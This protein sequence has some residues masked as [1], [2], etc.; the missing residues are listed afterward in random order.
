MTT[1]SGF[2]PPRG[3][4]TP[5]NIPDPKPK[6]LAGW[7]A[8]LPLANS[9]YC[10]DAVEAVL[11]S[12]NNNANLAAP[13]RLELAELLRPAVCMLVQR[14]ENHFIDAPLPHHP[15]AEFYAGLALR[16][17]RGLE[18]AYALAAFDPECAQG[19]FNKGERRLLQALYRAL[20]QGGLILLRTAQQYQTPPVDLWS[21]LY[22][23]YRIAEARNLLSAPFKDGEEPEA[24]RTPLGM[25]NRCLLF[26]LTSTRHLRQ[27]DMLHV[28]DLFGALADRAVL[29]S[30]A[31]QDWQTAE[32]SIHLDEDRPPFRSDS[33]GHPD[34]ANLRFL[35]TWKLTRM[36]ANAADAPEEFSV[37]DKPPINKAVLSRVV[38]SLEGIQ[39]RK[40]ERKPKDGTCRCLVGL[41]KI[42]GALSLPSSPEESSSP[43]SAS[44]FTVA[45]RLITRKFD[46]FSE[47]GTPIR[48]TGPGFELELEPESE[49]YNLYPPPP[50]NEIGSPKI[51]EGKFSARENIREAEETASFN[52][53]G[54]AVEGRIANVGARD[55]CIVWPADQVAEIKVGELIGVDEDGQSSLFIGVIRWLHCG[56]GRVRF[57]VELL[58]LSAEVA[59]LLDNSHHPM[60]KG[61]LLPSEP[62]LRSSPEL[63]TLPG[64]IQPGGMVCLG[65]AAQGKFYRV[66][67][68]LKGT[69]SF[70][71]FAIAPA[72]APVP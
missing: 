7:L 43:P 63:L 52:E 62:D 11:E 60:A 28:Y 59:E 19:W 18:M 34:K 6:A 14:A 53:S 16:L 36:L 56:E 12:F 25:F 50:R 8:D 44:D 29:S 5:I 68:L 23:L 1:M 61:L 3:S 66:Q 72:K 2:G 32:F 31:D 55:Y 58:T 15:K 38:R 13:T 26:A 10:S 57:G 48:S 37:K 24:C 51:L 46:G 22:R 9:R 17:H 49:E 45:E 20:Q 64:K 67:S 21:T 71:R 70:S 39:K 41:S 42:I 35:F 30:E 27:R 69:A 65:D 54:A 47:D 4:Q 40:A 33:T